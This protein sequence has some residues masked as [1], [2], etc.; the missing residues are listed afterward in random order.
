MWWRRPVWTAATRCRPLRPRCASRRRR[1]RRRRPP[2]LALR[3]VA[4]VPFRGNAA[5]SKM[6]P[7]VLQSND[8]CLCPWK[9]HI[10][11]TCHAR[12]RSCACCTMPLAC[13]AA[14]LFQTGPY[15][16]PVLTWL[17]RA[18]ARVDRARAWSQRRCAP[19]TARSCSARC[20]SCCAS[21][22][23]RPACPVQSRALHSGSGAL[24]RCLMFEL[25][26]NLGKHGSCLMCQLG[27]LGC[28]R[29]RACRECPQMHWQ[30]IPSA[31][32]GTA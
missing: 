13:G 15:F 19:C 31:V 23:T 9:I 14:F 11:M 6:L 25:F 3:C 26:T 7:Y 29:L 24:V 8:L 16:P 2:R 10:F 12:S 18:S 5:C 32:T 4:Y 22:G 20:P 1:W 28:T 17:C 30:Q 21:T 27:R